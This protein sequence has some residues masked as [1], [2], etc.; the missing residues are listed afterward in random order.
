MYFCTLRCSNHTH[1]WMGML[2]MMQVASR[3]AAVFAADATANLVTRLH[4]NVLRTGLRRL[5]TAYSRISLADVAAKLHLPSVEDTGVY[6]V[7]VT[8]PVHSHGLLYGICFL[9]YAVSLVSQLHL[10]SVEDT[11]GCGVV[12]ERM[13]RV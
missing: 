10:T 7:F 6:I 12:Y 13:R 3:H 4:H 1:T 5:A 2:Q 8:A 9:V 11:G